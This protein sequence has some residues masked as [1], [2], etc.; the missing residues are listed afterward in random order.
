[1]YSMNRLGFFAQFILS[2]VEGLRMTLKWGFVSSSAKGL[3]S[4]A[5]RLCHSRRDTSPAGM[6]CTEPSSWRSSR[7]PSSSTPWANP[8]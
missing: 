1:M 3:S 5:P 4:R 8:S 2:A 6:V 7:L